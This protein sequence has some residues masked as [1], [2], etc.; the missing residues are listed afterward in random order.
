MKSISRT[1]RRRL[2][3]AVVA[4]AVLLGLAGTTT[5]ARAGLN[6]APEARR[7]IVEQ[8]TRLKIMPLG[9]SITYGVGSSST[10]SYR[11]ALYWRL[12][13]AGV[14]V[15]FVGSMRSGQSPDPDNEGHKG[16]T[17]AQIAEHVD[18][19]L[20]TYEPDVILL[21]IG[22]NDMVRRVPDAGA[23]LNALLNRIA[24]D[25]PGAQVFVAKIVGLA[26][27]TDVAGQR[28]RTAAFN[29][30]VEA[31][32]ASKGA[33]FHLVDQSDVHGID[34]WNRE[35]PNDYGYAKMAWNWYR[36]LQPVLGN[37]TAWPASGDPYRAQFGT[38]CIQK[39]TL[40][41]ATEGC[42]TWYRRTPSMWQ[43]PVQQKRL[44]QTKI[45][46]KTIT[47]VRLVTR[48]ITAG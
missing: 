25:R 27:Y 1:V 24:A 9:D 10:D 34:M 43:L 14:G 22:T 30:A 13:A 2:A 7:P 3:A 19:W 35:H 37:G 31:V 26:D 6:G 38:R 28:R 15:D 8:A 11:S 45:K 33:D 42:H 46:G 29:R 17:I 44:Y 39:S 21:H 41:R 40:G 18:D 48:Y 4:P 32:V 20:A 47:R 5:P 16:W 12:N 36:A 23:Q